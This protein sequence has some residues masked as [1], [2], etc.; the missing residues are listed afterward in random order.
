MILSTNISDLR[1]KYRL[2]NYIAFSLDIDWAG[3]DLISETAGFFIENEIPITVFCTHPSQV[4]TDLGSHPL[5]ELGIHPNYAAGSS[6]GD[7]IAEV[8]DYCMELV[9]DARC[10]RGHRWYSSN[11]VYDI[12]V[13]RGILFDS[14]DCSMMDI[15]EPFIH[16][17]GIM[18]I[19]VF[20]EDGGL[21]WN[22]IEPDFSENGKHYFSRPCLKVVDL[23]PIHFMLNTPNYEYYR[24]VSDSFSRGEYSSMTAEETKKLRFSGAGMRNYIMELVEFI[25]ANNVYV[26]SLGRVYDELEYYSMTG[27]LNHEISNNS[28]R[29]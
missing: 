7:S 14:N 23:H 18:C 11:D 24:N 4:L 1:R 27:M 29:N 2:D 20:F 10:M 12:L 25:K 19:P 9:P 6:Q 5:V 16:R 3:E 22:N 28:F 8:T 26:T 13:E 21:L 17:S 15:V